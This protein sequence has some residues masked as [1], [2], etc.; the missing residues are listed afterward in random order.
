MPFLLTLKLPTVLCN[1]AVTAL[2]HRAELETW[3][4]KTQILA[5]NHPFKSKSQISECLLEFTGFNP[6]GNK[7]R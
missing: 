4:L 6:K 1:A 2:E 3:S 5:C 7:S